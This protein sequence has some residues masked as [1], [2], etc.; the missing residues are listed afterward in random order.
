MD[1][2]RARKASHDQ[3]EI[4]NK[5]DDSLTERSNTQSYNQRRQQMKES[6]ARTVVAEIEQSS[7]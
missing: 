5:K 6:H 2:I 4:G 7:Q 3:E 1:V